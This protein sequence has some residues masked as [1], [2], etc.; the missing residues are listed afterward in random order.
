MEPILPGALWLIAH[1]SMLGIHRPNKITL[2]GQDYVIWQNVKGEVFAL[3]NVC[4]HMQAPLS[5]GWV[6]QERDTIVCPFHALEFDGKGRLCQ[7][8]KKDTQ[9]ISKPLEVIVSNDCIWT[10]GGYE[11]RLPIPDLH[12]KVVNEYEFL[13]V[14][15]EK[16]IKGDFLSNLMVNYDYNHQNG[17]HKDL[18]KITSC[19]VTAFEP[20][21]YYAKVTQ[22]LTRADNT[23]KEML[24]NPV[25]GILPKIMHN[26]LE[27]AFPSTTV[28]FSKAPIA[29]IAQF[30]ILYPETEKITRTFILMYAKFMNPM[31]KL[32][33]KNSVLQAAATVVEQDSTAVETLYPREKPKI[34][35]PNEEIMF[36]AEKLYRDW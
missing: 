24:Q 13:G 17:T 3:N 7:I 28:L 19:N 6:C 22:N 33:F 20:Q 2:N 5:N 14:T 25:V 9:P 10:Y 18:F 35:L 23:W 30:H 12:Q 16:I 32:V 34:R 26:Q 21:G 29:D 1:K 15:G 8:D 36:Y 11:P 4:P 27:Y 31:M